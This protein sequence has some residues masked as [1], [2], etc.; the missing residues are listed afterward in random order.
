MNKTKLAMDIVKYSN[1]YVAYAEGRLDHSCAAQFEE[2]LLGVIDDCCEKDA[3][4]VLDMQNVEYM[5]SVGLRVLMIA[6]KKCNKE[7]AKVVVCGLQPIMLE[8]FQISRFDKIF[9]VFDT[10][11]DALKEVDP[12]AFLA[13]SKS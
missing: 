3:T 7:E 8:I 2:E 5:S 11:S 12:E 6:A 9:K 4:V 1:T 10:L 13:Y